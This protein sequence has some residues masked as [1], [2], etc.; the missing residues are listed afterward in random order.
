M[1]CGGLESDDGDE[2]LVA[3][4]VTPDIINDKWNWAARH[5]ARK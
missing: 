5:L 1:H 3:L 4:S 2:G